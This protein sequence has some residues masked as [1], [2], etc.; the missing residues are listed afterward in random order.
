M[1]LR[2]LEVLLSHILLVLLKV[3]FYVSEFFKQIVVLKNFEVFDVEVCLIAPSK[4]L[5][6]LPL[7]DTFQNTES[8]EV[9]EREL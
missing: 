6:R 9:G 1:L 8:P 2:P 3:C 7:V 5:L 4:L